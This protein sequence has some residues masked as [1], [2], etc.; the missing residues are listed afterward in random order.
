MCGLSVTDYN[1][2]FEPT[3]STNGGVLT[4]INKN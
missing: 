1:F 3:A 2:E 4:F